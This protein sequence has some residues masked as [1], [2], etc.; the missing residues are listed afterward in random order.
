MIAVYTFQLQTS[1]M[2][3]EA[4]T[5][6][7]LSRSEDVQA[8]PGKMSETGT[9]LPPRQDVPRDAKAQGGKGRTTSEP[10]KGPLLLTSGF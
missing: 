3:S 9:M 2:G 6:V 5:R 4:T 10:Q 8:H 7:L 1:R